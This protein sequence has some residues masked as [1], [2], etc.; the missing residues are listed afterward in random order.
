VKQIIIAFVDRFSA[1]ATRERDMASANG[2]TDKQTGI[3]EDVKLFEVF[4]EQVSQ[5]IQ[6]RT[7]F[8]T[9]DEVALLLSLMNLSCSCYSNR[10]DYVVQVFDFCKSRLEVA[11]QCVIYRTVSISVSTYC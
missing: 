7:E 6:N 3:P 1:Y 2:A 9:E 8:S 10:L 5:V 11:A 4:W